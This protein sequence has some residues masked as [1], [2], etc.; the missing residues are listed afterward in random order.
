VLPKKKKKKVN[1]RILAKVISKQIEEVE[2]IPNTT[3]SKNCMVR[4]VIA[5]LLRIENQ[6]QKP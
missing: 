3:N 5:K 6:E 1:Q 4:Y 2:Q